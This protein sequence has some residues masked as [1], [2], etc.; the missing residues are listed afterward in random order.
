MR[1]QFNGFAI[2]LL[3]VVGLVAVARNQP[4]VAQPPQALHLQSAPLAAAFVELQAEFI[5]SQLGQADRAPGGDLCDRAASAHNRLENS[6]QKGALR[7]KHVAQLQVKTLWLKKQCAHL[8]TS[9]IPLIQELQQ[10]ARQVRSQLSQLPAN[11][12]PSLQVAKLLS[13]PLELGLN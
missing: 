1:N 13:N 5:L 12:H 6:I 10:L 8:S 9:D 2:V 3:C 4:V 11:P 7:S